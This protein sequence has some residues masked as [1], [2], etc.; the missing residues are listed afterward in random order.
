MSY[1]LFLGEAVVDN[2][3]SLMTQKMQYSSMRLDWDYTCS[4][5]HSN[6]TTT[7]TNELKASST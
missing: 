3:K 5:H 7:V 4:V 2:R 1:K 6:S